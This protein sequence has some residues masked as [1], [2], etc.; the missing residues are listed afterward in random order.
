MYKL[1]KRRHKVVKTAS[2]RELRQKTAALLSEVRKGRGVVI[3]YRGK[4]VAL[5]T[6]L[7]KVAPPEFDSA[8][9][10]MWKG[11]PQMRSVEKWLKR[12][13]ASRYKR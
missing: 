13:R 5:L 12:L 11:R 9:F 1:Q 4:S 6:P 7:R 10:G 2:A 3:T 8:G